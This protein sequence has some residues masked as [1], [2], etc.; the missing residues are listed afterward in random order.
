MAYAFEILQETLQI[1]R[2]DPTDILT[3]M[4]HAAKLSIFSLTATEEEISLVAPADFELPMPP[5]AVH[6]VW[7]AL[8][9]EGPL[10]FSAIG[11]LADISATLAEAGISI[12]VIST[13]DTDYVLVKAEKL[14]ATRKALRAAG[15]QLRG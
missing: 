13:F 2:F 12:F 14:D 1:Y 7:R 11:I 6:G 15:H 8:K 10:D 4:P 3:V 5:R 9:V